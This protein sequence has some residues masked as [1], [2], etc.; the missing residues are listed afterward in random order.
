MNAEQVVRNFFAAVEAGDTV[1]ANN[2]LTDD[3]TFSGPVPQPIG[4]A[5]FLALSSALRDA[6]PDWKFN[7]QNF[8][9]QG[10]TV[11]VTVQITGTHTA[12]LQPHIPGIPAVPATGKK[13]ALPQEPITMQVRGDKIASFEV[14]P[15]PGG[16]VPGILAQIGV[17]MPH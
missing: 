13:I 17:Q 5:E 3:F 8:K 2:F 10:N 15:V 14:T 11:T 9:V 1:Q 12:T 6:I 7:A 16:G 4:K